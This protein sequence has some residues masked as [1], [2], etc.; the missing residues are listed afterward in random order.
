MKNMLDTKK[1]TM[2]KKM[3]LR[4]TAIAVLL[5]SV[6]AFAVENN[7]FYRGIR[8]LGMGDAFTSIANDE[9]AA[10]YNPAGLAS[11]S[12]GR[13]ELINPLIEVGTN[14]MDFYSDA[15][16][17]NTGD[18][19]SA[20]N[21]MKKNIGK[22]QHARFS[23][24]PNYT[25]HNFEIGIIGQGTVDGEIHTPAYPVMTLDVK[26]DAGALAAIAG[27]FMEDRLQ[28][29]GTL[30]Y[31]QRTRFY[32][33]FTAAMVAN[34]N[35]S[36]S[37]D[38]DKKTSS[39]IG[40]DVGAIYK[41]KNDTWKPQVGLAILNVGDMNFGDMTVTT[42]SKPLE[43]K[44]NQSVNLGAS[45]SYQLAWASI[46]GAV[47][48]KDIASNTSTDA[49]KGKKLHVGFEAKLPKILSVRAGWNQGYLGY[50]LGVDFW[51]IKL[52]YAFYKEEVGAYA[53]QREDER[54]VVQLVIG[55]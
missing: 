49:D 39:T 12:E 44:L 48:I 9:N 27:T 21:L 17:L 32:K 53:G 55:W 4:L 40:L 19:T 10:F 6:P 8:P 31:V 46:L 2:N 38:Q 11:V 42:L 43:N 13:I 35:Q 28:L 52:S 1:G 16:G 18:T 54:H 51:L 22:H 30:K 33:D 25:R 23:I 7:S 50:G 36:Y 20:V 47:D 41:F 29:G 37:F 14:T 3:L 26:V 45:A 34:S 15:T 24:F 5:S